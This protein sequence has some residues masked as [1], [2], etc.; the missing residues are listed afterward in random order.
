V[1]ARFLLDTTI[2]SEQLKPRPKASIVAGIKKHEF[3]LAIASV[4]WHEL[5]YGCERLPPSARR[6][7][8]EDYFEQRVGATMEILP[9][10]ARAAGWHAVERVRLEAKGKTP[11]FRDG[12]IAAIAAV[13]D[14]V[15]VT[16]NVRDFAGF[17]GLRV[18]SWA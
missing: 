8:F 12:Q 11:P 18:E 13:N 2:V 5:R 3:E 4:V 6:T 10:D 1:S 17:R 16:S 7:M 14:L 9:Y 15:L